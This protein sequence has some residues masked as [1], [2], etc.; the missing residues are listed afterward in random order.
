MKIIL[1]KRDGACCNIDVN[2]SRGCAA[3]LL[4]RKE[5]VFSQQRAA[6]R[7]SPFQAGALA[8]GGYMCTTAESLG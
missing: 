3:D 6:G 2:I 1:S 5:S 4:L 8:L 7:Y